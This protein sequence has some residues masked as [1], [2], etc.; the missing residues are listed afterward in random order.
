MAIFA[1]LSNT[2][3][4]S[5]SFTG[6]TSPRA[7][8]HSQS[9]PALQTA[10]SEDSSVFS[11]LSTSTPPPVLRSSQKKRQSK[12]SK[13]V[14]KAREREVEVQ[15]VED[16]GANVTEHTDRF[17]ISVQ[18][19]E[20]E[21]EEPCLSMTKSSDSGSRSFLRKLPTI[22]DNDTAFYNDETS[23]IRVSVAASNAQQNSYLKPTDSGEYDESTIADSYYEGNSRL[24]LVAEVPVRE[25]QN[26]ERITAMLE[27]HEKQMDA[28]LGII[29]EEDDDDENTD[30]DARE[31][32][33]GLR[34][35]PR[36][37]RSE[38]ERP[39]L[40]QNQARKMQRVLHQ[41]RREVE[42]L[43][44]NNEQF[45]SEIEQTEEEHESEMKLVE[46]RNKQKI[47]ELRTVYL[48]EI[49][50]L[51]KEKDAAIV[52][53]GRQAAQYAESARKQVG[54]LKRQVEKIKS[55]HAQI[56]KAAVKE[57]V[58]GQIALVK[59]QKEEE[60]AT[61][62]ASIIED[63]E[64]KLAKL[65]SESNMKIRNA[66]DKAMDSST[67]QIA[68]DR[69]DD[70]AETI[71]L[72]QRHLEKEKKA[73][74]QAGAQQRRSLQQKVTETTEKNMELSRER[75]AIMNML[76]SLKDDLKTFHA[77]KLKQFYAQESRERSESKT[78]LE[79]L[80]QEV[81][82][83]QSFIL[84]NAE[85]KLEFNQ[86]TEVNLRHEIEE[87]RKERND[88][89][90][91][92][93]QM[94][95]S[96]RC[97]ETEEMKKQKDNTT[98]KTKRLEEALKN[99]GRD[100]RVLEDKYR[101]LTESH[102]LEVQKLRAEKDAMLEIEKGRK[103]LAVAMAAGQRELAHTMARAKA[104]FESAEKKNDMQP[105]SSVSAMVTKG[106]LDDTAKSTAENHGTDIQNNCVSKLRSNKPI[107]SAL[108]LAGEKESSPRDDDSSVKRSDRGFAESPR[109]GRSLTPTA[110]QVAKQK[111]R[112]NLA[113]S[114]AEL[115]SK[116]KKEVKC[117]ENSDTSSIEIDR[118]KL[119]PILKG[120]RPNQADQSDPRQPDPPQPDPPQ[121]DP[122]G[123]KR[124]PS[125]PSPRRQAMKNF[126][127]DNQ[128]DESSRTRASLASYTDESTSS[129]LV[130]SGAPS[131]RS[132]KR[133]LA[134]RRFLRSP[135]E[136]RDDLESLDSKDDDS[137]RN[138]AYLGSE[139]DI[140]PSQSASMSSSHIMPES[141][142]PLDVKE[143][144]TKKGPLGRFSRMSTASSKTLSLQKSSESST[145]VNPSDSTSSKGKSESSTS[146][147]TSTLASA[148]KRDSRR[149]LHLSVESVNTQN[150]PCDPPSSTPTYT[151]KLKKKWLP[152]RQISTSL[153]ADDL[154]GNGGIISPVDLGFRRG[155]RKPPLPGFTGVA[156]T[157]P[158]DKNTLATH[159]IN[160]KKPPVGDNEKIVMQEVGKPAI[161]VE[162]AAILPAE[163]QSEG[164][165]PGTISVRSPSKKQLALG[166]GHTL[167]L[168]P[169]S[170]ARKGQHGVDPLDN[171][172]SSLTPETF[173]PGSATQTAATVDTTDDDDNNNQDSQSE[174]RKYPPLGD[175]SDDDSSDDSTDKYTAFEPVQFSAKGQPSGKRVPIVISRSVDSPVMSM[176][177]KDENRP[178]VVQGQPI[179]RQPS[180]SAF[181]PAK[182]MSSSGSTTESSVSQATTT[183]TAH[184]LRSFTTSQARPPLSPRGNA[185]PP[186]SGAKRASSF[187]ASLKSR[188]SSFRGRSAN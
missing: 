175:E 13:G 140:S 148:S 103:E 121:S 92:L 17:R 24:K 2:P 184:T 162:Q 110:R 107:L 21:H 179:Y 146:T 10:K 18:S 164:E 182:E 66:I 11:G 154:E 7:I 156:R 49:D 88:I 4:R 178:I 95:Q 74:L 32:L 124:S 135:S 41:A 94:R 125:K 177:S 28:N 62:L 105:A 91:Q 90:A 37:V 129:L 85:K 101:K 14:K 15:F 150:T 133:R 136:G 87:T 127:D 152:E 113:K 25:F 65:R 5:G 60:Y 118:K 19:S 96:C 116:A 115:E 23:A 97:A 42:L 82:K 183:I 3:S 36:L 163:Q 171:N 168:Q 126:F 40:S 170:I 119:F 176:E 58:Q 86:E 143:N 61:K 142:R 102:R 117:E 64:T 174:M 80:V 158:S 76:S 46:N 69:D 98:E 38:D 77:E 12:N 57:A 185:S 59:R 16:Y 89:Y 120:F 172:L 50:L 104:S 109:R 71:S 30:L 128:G 123:N 43:R 39:L 52:E 155:L 149:Q 157:A 55:Q 79:K 188:R 130:E 108:I 75:E 159:V 51:T 139:A 134:R 147:S 137:R 180:R 33:F 181:T 78:G 67:H 112:E 106:V 144:V 44:D 20:D 70:V 47:S 93:Q 73:V 48:T 169:L 153:E 114:A 100:K 45:M 34:G 6:A 166:K 26:E 9:A 131:P 167:C 54:L 53:A 186:P 72:F 141:V 56:V 165:V 1:A 173:E 27:E 122:G 35:S 132:A 22:T 161:T 99:L 8:R 81:F 160:G 111:I 84:D 83:M 145:S 187:K 31:A 68:T 29:H 63:Y 138:Q 151:I